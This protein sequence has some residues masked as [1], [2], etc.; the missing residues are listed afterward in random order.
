MIYYKIRLSF[1]KNI[2]TIRKYL[3][4]I[5]KNSASINNINTNNTKSTKRHTNTNADNTNHV[6]LY[7]LQWKFACQTNIKDTDI[8]YVSNITQCINDTSFVA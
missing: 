2:L 8:K 1:F 6:T 4:N 7:T 3:S 5:T